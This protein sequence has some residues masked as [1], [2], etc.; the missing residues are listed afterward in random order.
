METQIHRHLPRKD[1][2]LYSPKNAEAVF[3]DNLERARF[4]ICAF[5][6]CSNVHL[7]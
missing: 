7:H 1:L 6:V 5:N 3:S 4:K 2:D